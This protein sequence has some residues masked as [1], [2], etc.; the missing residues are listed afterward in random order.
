MSDTRSN[1]V[2]LIAGTRDVGKTTLVKELIMASNLPKKL[3]VDEFDSRVWQNMK[4]FSHPEW[5]SVT[6]PRI[7]P[8]Q[9]PH[10]N[11]G[12]YRLFDPDIE[13]MIQ[14]V[15]LNVFDCFIVLEDATRYFDPVLTKDQKRLVLNTKQNN[16][17]LV[18]VFHSLADIPP[19]LLRY[20]NFL[21]VMKTDEIAFDKKKFTHPQFASVFNRVLKS[22]NKH[23]HEVIKLK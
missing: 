15:V 1:Q 17:D 16:C 12:T 9:L 5:E 4:T 20:S 3:V 22:K 13:S 19:R 10:W 14:E 23:Y 7:F 6:L 2:I 18:L 11:S 8:N 21:V